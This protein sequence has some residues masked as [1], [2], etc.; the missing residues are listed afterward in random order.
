MDSDEAVECLTYCWLNCSKSYGQ[1][2][3]ARAIL[4][5]LHQEHDWYSPTDSS[6]VKTLF[7]GLQK[8]PRSAPQLKR[9]ALPLD[10]V[11]Q[12]AHRGSQLASSTYLFKLILVL[13][14]LGMR[15]MARGIE[16]ARLR[17]SDLEFKPTGGL[18]I[19]FPK[20]K[21]KPLGRVIFIDETSGVLCPVNL[22]RQFVAMRRAQGAK[23]D[24]HL[25]VRPGCRK[26]SMLDTRYIT[27]LIRQAQTLLKYPGSYSS[28]SMRIGGCSL[29]VARGL[30]M[31]KL[32]IIGDWTSS[33][34]ERY[35]R[36]ARD[37]GIALSRE[38]GF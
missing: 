18:V 28:H 15:T 26:Q 7:A 36:Q 24:N 13:M 38:M 16:L 30:S 5:K 33:A 12:W 3:K 8:Q 14:V 11:K 23:N 25:F 10:M 2:V 1:T 6:R 4:K 19:H 21:T 9:D 22:V 35:F 29:G 31:E 17:L 34:I 37:Q 20:T 27:K 32:M